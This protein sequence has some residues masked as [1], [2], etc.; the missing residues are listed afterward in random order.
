VETGD[1]VDGA[2]AAAVTAAR[3]S[4]GDELLPAERQAA[5]AAVARLKLNVDL[6]DEH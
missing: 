2:A 4:A 1:E 6:V 5:V 3:T